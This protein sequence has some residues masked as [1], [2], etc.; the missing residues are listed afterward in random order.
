M[1]EAGNQDVILRVS[2]LHKLYARNQASARRRLGAL[3]SRALTGQAPPSVDALAE[4]QEFWALRDISFE[5][6]RGEALGVIG[7]N[8]SG[9]TTLLRIL[10]GQ[11]LPDRGEVWVNGSTAAMIDLQAGFQSGASGRENIFLR[12]AALGF[13]RKQTNKRLKEI[14]DFAELG[15]AIDAPMASY[16][17]GMKMRLA[18]SVMAMVHPDVLLIDEVLSVG[19]FRFR[20]KSLAKIREMRTRSAFVLVSHSLTQIEGFCDRVIVLNK[21]RVHFAGE[22][23]QAIEAYQE[24]DRETV[25]HETPI[26]LVKAMGESFDNAGAL[27][28][29][30]HY[31]CDADGTPVETVDFQDKIRLLVSFTASVAVRNL[32]IGVPIWNVNAHYMTGLSTKISAQRVSLEAGERASFMLEVEPAILNPGTIKSM[33]TILDGAEFF[34]RQPNPDLTIRSTAHPTWGVVTVPHRWIRLESP[35]LDQARE[36]HTTSAS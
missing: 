34:Y 6:Q 14:I 8:G 21:G 16:S 1:S 26:N 7:L 9:K 20:Q 5:L 4:K 25:S 2:G 35:T 18:F 27:A 30:E 29:V 32:V 11:L 22:P 3:V 13:S 31:W 12:A 10:A 17:S 24:L 36:K 28:N 23:K 33:L 19:D 15:D